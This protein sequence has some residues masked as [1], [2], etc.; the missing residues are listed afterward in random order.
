MQKRDGFIFKKKTIGHG[1]PLVMFGSVDFYEKSFSPSFFKQFE[2]TLIDYRAYAKTTNIFSAQDFTEE[3]IK[4]DLLF[5]LK[6]IPLTKPFFLFSHSA[7]TYLSLLLLEILPIEW[8]QKLKGLIMV[9]SGSNSITAYQ[10]NEKRWN[11]LK[12][13]LRKISDQNYQRTFLSSKQPSFVNYCKAYHSRSWHDYSIDRNSIWDNIELNDQA[14]DYI[15]K[16]IF[17]H[18]DL[19][20]LIKLVHVPVLN[21]IGESDYLV[22]PQDEWKKD[23]EINHHWTFKKISAAGHYPFLENPEEFHHIICQW[24]ESQKFSF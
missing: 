8:S 3:K 21:L 24:I 7:H 19:K 12:D 6:S 2:L 15:Y 14:L 11:E 17:I 10:A 1:I 16:N 9:G 5:L 4:E 23:F 22:A 20:K 18:I 13:P